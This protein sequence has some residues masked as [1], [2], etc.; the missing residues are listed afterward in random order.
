MRQQ[1][2]IELVVALC[3]IAC[4]SSNNSEKSMTDE[5]KQVFINKQFEKGAF[6]ANVT[7]YA[8]FELSGNVKQVTNTSVGGPVYVPYPSTSIEFGYDGRICEAKLKDKHCSPIIERDLNGSIKSLHIGSHF[9]WDY[10]TNDEEDPENYYFHFNSSQHLEKVVV[11]DD[12]GFGEENNNYYYNHN[13][14]LSSIS[15]KEETY[16]GGYL[17]RQETFKITDII[18]DNHHNWVERVLVGGHGQKIKEKREITY[19]IP[20]SLIPIS[21]VN[22]IYCYI[23]KDNLYRVYR[24]NSKN[25]TWIDIIDE[26]Y[27]NSGIIYMGIRD[28]KVVETRLYIMAV[29]GACGAPGNDLHVCYLDVKNNRWNFVIACNEDSEFVKNKIKA[30]VFWITKEGEYTIENEYG[31]SIA[32]IDMQCE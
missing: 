3:F 6:G 29:T 5:E 24:Y 11:S 17:S 1:R 12:W 31:D 8:A 18:E 4:T 30:H 13:N 20:P 22:N 19:H 7:D 21:N 2:F 9:V 32:W 14:V 16:E 25:D 27:N 15:R 28:Y 23:Y 10:E 26:I